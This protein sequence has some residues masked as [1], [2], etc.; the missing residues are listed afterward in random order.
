MNQLRL[1]YPVEVL[2][3]T[4]GISRS[5]FYAREGRPPLQRAKTDAVFKPLIL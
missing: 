3:Q 2:T 1:Q 5:G 4:I